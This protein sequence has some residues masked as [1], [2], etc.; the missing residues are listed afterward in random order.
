MSVGFGCISGI[1]TEKTDYQSEAYIFLKE[2]V[3]LRYVTCNLYVNTKFCSIV[4]IFFNV[5][6]L[7]EKIS[8]FHF[9]YI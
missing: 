8:I 7:L 9:D 1:V 6:S 2:T 4:L 3:F 5:E